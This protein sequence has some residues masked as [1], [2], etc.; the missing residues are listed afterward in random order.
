MFAS[1][2]G[3]NA[4]ANKIQTRRYD[5]L[6]RFRTKSNSAILFIL[7]Y[8][9][10][11][12]EQTKI[13]KNDIRKQ[14]GC[15]SPRWLP[16]R[17][18]SWDIRPYDDGQKRRNTEWSMLVFPDLFQYPGYMLISWISSRDQN[19]ETKQKTVLFILISP[20]KLAFSRSSLLAQHY[21]SQ[22][23]QSSTELRFHI[24]TPPGCYFRKWKE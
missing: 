14:T 3:G 22:S 2:Q 11:S 10:F 18:S 13:A 15:D 8:F 20:L 4:G 16:L 19:T 12:V 6:K 7:F 1:S 21:S 17:T 24:R 9:A 23:V 5:A